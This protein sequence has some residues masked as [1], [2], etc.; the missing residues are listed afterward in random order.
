MKGRVVKLS[1]IRTRGLTNVKQG[2]KYWTEPV[3]GIEVTH[4]GRPATQ[5]RD[6]TVECSLVH[7]YREGHR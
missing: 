1:R 5:I 6:R 4:F 3:N 2:D 7:P